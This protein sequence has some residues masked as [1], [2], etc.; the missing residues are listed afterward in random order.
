MTVL[1]SA[2]LAA[3]AVIALAGCSLP[4][5]GPRAHL[6]L[7]PAKDRVSK[8]D[9]CLV[10]L[11]ERTV[12]IANENSHRIAGR[13]QDRRRPVNVKFGVGDSVAVTIF[14]SAAGGL[15][16]SAKGGDRG[17]FITLPPQNVDERGNIF[18]PYAGRIRAAGRTA[19]LIQSQIVGRLK[20]RALDPQAVVTL[21]AQRDAQLSVLGTVGTPSRIPVS[22]SGERMLDAIARAGGISIPGYE[23]WV[24]L[25]RGGRIAAAPFE[26]LIHEPLNNIYVRPQDIIY[27]FRSPQTFVALG[28]TGQQSHVP[29]GAWRLSIAEGLGKAGGLN[30]A[31]A[32]PA[33]VFIYRFESRSAVKA[34]KRKCDFPPEEKR[35]PVVYRLNLRDPS[36][37]FLARRMQMRNKDV[38]YVSNATSVEVDKFLN[39]FRGINAAV[40]DPISTAIS[41]YALRAAARGTGSAVVITS[42]APVSAP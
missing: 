39:H 14:E 33:W 38:I 26:A 24:L 42:S 4:T 9:Y 12:H 7:A 2:A 19:S 5:N 32:E 16:F 30:Q 18:V 27:V 23:A 11:D 20:N 35:V 8:V 17:N 28:A 1:R 22:A 40:A 29:F 31:L 13:F 36:G 3:L 15:F 34:L 37:F 10:E 41:A 6:I 21:A 25:E